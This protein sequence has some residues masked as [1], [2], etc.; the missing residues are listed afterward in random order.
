MSSTPPSK[1][2]PKPAVDWAALEPHYRAGIRSL[3]EIGEEF[4]VSDAGIIKHAG[5]NGWTRDL[6]AKIRAKA[7]AKV[8][9]AAVSPEVSNAN[10]QRESVIVEAAATTMF[11]VRMAHR[12]DIARS[13]SLFNVL[14]GELEVTSNPEGQGLIE[15]L[16]DV[17]RTPDDDE[18]EEQKKLRRKRQSDALAKVLAIPERVDTFKRLM[19][20]LDRLTQLERQA[21]GI[22]DKTPEDPNAGL[23][24]LTETER[25][26]RLATMIQLATQRRA[27]AEEAKPAPATNAA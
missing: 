4:G 19:E 13:K 17:L 21:F 15:S 23:P 8:S 6:T 2:A 7:E 1:K 26:S 10:R 5:K 3:K 25:A 20:T 27:A 22:T 24:T 16:M 14:I 12:K 18:N 11:N 9:A